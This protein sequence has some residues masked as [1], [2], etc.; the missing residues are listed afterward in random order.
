MDLKLTEEQIK[1]LKLFAYYCKSHGADEVNHSVYLEY[2]QPESWDDNF[3]SPQTKSPIE[4]YQK[5]IDTIYQ[6][7]EDSNIIDRYFEDCENRGEVYVNIDCDERILTL[8]LSENVY[9]DEPYGDSM[10]IDEITDKFGEE[11]KVEIEKLFELIGPSRTGTIS[12]NG[13]GDDGYIEGE[14]E[15]E[16]SREEVSKIIEEFTYSWLNS[17]AAGWENNEGGF[18]RF[19]FDPDN[20]DVV[21]DFNYN[22]EEEQF[23]HTISFNF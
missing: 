14:I 2:C 15:I 12:L 22:T 7:I 21:L 16:D 19:I 5:I 4:G 1:T 9:G 6:I 18:G 10:D 13:G 3:Y 11:T 23:R 17:H 8:R 20:D